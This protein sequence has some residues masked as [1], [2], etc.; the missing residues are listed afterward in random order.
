MDVDVER[1]KV[2]ELDWTPPQYLQE[3][4]RMIHQETM[5]IF[6]RKT[7]VSRHGKDDF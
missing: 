6:E 1:D 2:I 3:P 4:L 7:G 5:L